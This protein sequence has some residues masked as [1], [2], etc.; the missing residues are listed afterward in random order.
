MAGIGWKLEAMLERDSLG[1]SVGVFLTGAAVTSGP[2]LLTTLVLVLMQISAVSSG[3]GLHDAQAVITLV[4]ATVIVLGAPVDIVLSRYTADRVYERR[5]EQIVAPLRRTLAGCLVGF[6]A[7][8]PVVMLVSGAPRALAVPGVALTVV[9]GA[10]WLLLSAAGGLSSP[11]IILRAFLV[12][13]PASLIAALTLARPQ[14]LGAPGYLYGFAAGQVVTLAMLLWGTLRALPAEEDEGARILPAFR[15][16]WLLG[17]ATL[18]FHASL[19][20]DKLVVLAVRGGAAAATYATLAAV[21]WLSVVPA[22]AY[23]FVTVETALYRRFEAFDVALHR[24]APMA[25]LE[26]LAGDL[27]AEADRL[28]RG[29]IGVQGSVALIGLMVAPVVV[30]GLG[31]PG[32]APCLRWLLVGASLQVLAVAATLLLHY[33]DF[34]SGALATALTQLIATAVLTLLIGAPGIGY[35]LGCALACAVAIAL[36]RRRLGRLIQHTFLSQPYPAEE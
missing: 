21:A 15:D 11:G 23:V 1:S 32:Q 12:G 24:G 36:V 29:V 30:A 20:V 27:R 10:Q 3:A 8:G 31:L 28:L 34:R 2:W 13:S 14:L 4:Y 5:P 26:A 18:A 19:W 35:A 9:V 16:Y 25:R 33:F 22:C 17:V 6:A 7:V